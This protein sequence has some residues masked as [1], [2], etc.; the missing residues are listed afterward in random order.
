[1]TYFVYW[2][3]KAMKENNYL[4]V[5]RFGSF[6]NVRQKCHAQYFI[7]GKNYFSAVCD[8]ILSAKS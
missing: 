3:R 8:A 4:S 5:K 7:D 2:L 1:M 6:A